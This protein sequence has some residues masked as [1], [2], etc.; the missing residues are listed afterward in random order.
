MKC[1]TSALVGY[2]AYPDDKALVEAMR[3]SGAGWAVE[4]IHY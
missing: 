4:T 1:P 2:D 3:V